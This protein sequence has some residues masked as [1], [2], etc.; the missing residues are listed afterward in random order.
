MIVNVTFVASHK[1]ISK[2]QTGDTHMKRSFI[3]NVVASNG[4]ML[5]S[6]PIKEPLMLVTAAVCNTVGK[7]LL[8][9]G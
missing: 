7:P 1:A 8:P 5:G 4:Y 6:T 2:W 9:C 3:N